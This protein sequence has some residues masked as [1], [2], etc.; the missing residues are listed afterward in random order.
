MKIL[1]LDHTGQI[2]GAELFLL[3]IAQQYRDCLVVTFEEGPFVEALREAGVSVKCFEARDI[4]RFR[5]TSGIDVAL[6]LAPSLLALLKEITNISA[7]F[8]LIYANSKKAAPLAL[9]AGQLARKPVFVHIHD[10]LDKR[11]FSWWSRNLFV[12]MTNLMAKMVVA[13]STATAQAFVELGG[14]KRKL[15]IVNNGFDPQKFVEENPDD[16]A[17]LRL[18]LGLSNGP[19]LGC[20]GRISEGKGQHVL[21]E[22]LA[23]LPANVQV[24]LVGSAPFGEEGYLEVL[25]EQAKSPALT[26]RVKF[27]GFRTDVPALINLCD[28]I[29]HPAIHPEAFGRSLVEAQLAKRPVIATNIGG[30]GEIITD[31]ETGLL[32][33]SD[34][35]DDLTNRINEL[36]DDR[37]LREKLV[38]QGYESAT[39]KFGM[40][41]TFKQ[42]DDVIS[43]TLK[44]LNQGANRN[45][46]RSGTPVKNIL[47]FD[48]TAQLSGGELALLGLVRN[49]DKSKFKA[50]VVLGAEGPLAE[51]I[52]DSSIDVVILPLD[53]EVLDTKKESLN[54]VALFQLSKVLNSL[55]YAL[56]LAKLAKSLRADLIHTNSLK[57]DVIGGL[58]GRIAAIP[59]IWHVRDLIT[60]DYLPATAVVVFRKLARILPTFIIGNSNATLTT[61]ALPDSTYS[62]VIYS[63]VDL[64]NIPSENNGLAGEWQPSEVLTIG[65]IGRLSRWKGQHIFIQAAEVVHKNFP[66]VT[67]QIIGGALFGEH[68]YVAELHALTSKLKLENCVHFTGHVAD[69][70]SILP[71][72]DIIAHASTSGEPFGRVIV[73]G[74]AHG[75]PVIATDGGG[76]PEVIANNETGLLVPMNDHEALAKAMIRLIKDPKLAMALGRK[77]KQ[78]AMEAFSVEQTTE[79]VERVFEKIVCRTSN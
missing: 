33:K 52:R 36:L 53:P 4:E 11:Y 54:W 7:D 18:E 3:E 16:L 2:G 41:E 21:L 46:T 47:F 5:R 57:S 38:S 29:I 45:L 43:K 56:K 74:M 72:L 68:D 35:V 14:A 73:E 44:P 62:K 79:N 20:I 49:L 65:V 23:T 69:V 61:L 12:S 25:K 37:I 50:T 8:D 67:F 10:I 31:R 26:S 78:R 58:A 28:L 39:R 1:F 13:N 30:I 19:I 55:L 60:E 15:E 59:V 32:C 40:Q 24:L 64:N 70:Q 71:K 77:G 6:S 9:V 76:V 51:K 75:K 22:A 48:H 66:N 34:D 27:A 17:K 42:F 63:G